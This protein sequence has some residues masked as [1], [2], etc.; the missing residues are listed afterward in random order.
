MAKQNYYGS[1]NP[2]AAAKALK[3]ADRYFCQ[4]TE[5]GTIY[6]G[7]GYV[8]F[9]L[10]PADYAA[11]VQPVACCEAGNWTIDRNGKSESSIDAA[12]IFSEAVKTAQNA[13]DLQSCPLVINCKQ[14]KNP[15]AAYYNAEADF[16]ALYNPAYIAAF[17]GAT[18]RTSSA[19]S[20]AIMYNSGEA[21]GLV[22][23]IRAEPKT[24]RAVKAYFAEADD[25]ND[26]NAEA[27]KLRGQ[28]A[29]RNAE[30]LEARDEI[31]ALRGEIN[32]L[33][34]EVCELSTVSAEAVPAAD[35]KPEPKTAAEIIAAR[36]AEVDG[37]TATIKGAQTAAPVVWL[38]GDTKPHAKAIEAD[39]GKWSTKKNAYYFR[40]A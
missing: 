33:Q 30:L 1:F 18:I 4:I 36:W 2:S 15:A 19:C 25:D 20:A 22:M 26:N 34:A 8:L 16:V 35:N 32:D 21:V 23:P 13:A 24:A 12:H 11:I 3:M 6:A 9:K 17:P 29:A 31:K 5:D 14:G 7:S 39:G 37:L 38:A 40:V 28:L 27:E 10:T